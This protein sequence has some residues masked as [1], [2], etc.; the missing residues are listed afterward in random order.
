MGQEG[1]T[2]LYLFVVPALALL[3]EYQAS[4]R[5]DCA[6]AAT[7]AL[8]ACAQWTRPEGGDFWETPLH[9]PNPLAAGHAAVAYEVGRRV[10][11]VERY[12][13]WAVWWLRSM[14]AFTHLWEPAGTPMLYDT[15]P[16]LCSSDWYFAN[17]V[18][19]HVQ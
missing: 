18:R 6:E 2:A 3:T 11:G 7:G 13:E 5:T 8:D 16:C 10:L 1:D 14:L 19:D 9:A 4:G 15:K 12:G 17:W